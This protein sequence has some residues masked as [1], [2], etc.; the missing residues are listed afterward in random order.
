[1]RSQDSQDETASSATNRSARSLSSVW[2]NSGAKAL[3]R[4]WTSS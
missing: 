3:E 1:M 4:F 2:A